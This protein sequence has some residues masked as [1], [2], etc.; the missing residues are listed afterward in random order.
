MAFGN[1]LYIYGLKEST[2][3]GLATMCITSAVLLGYIVSIFRYDES[4][5]YICL[6]GSSLIVIGLGITLYQNT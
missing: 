4:L 5:D 1:A 3:T 6:I 2:N